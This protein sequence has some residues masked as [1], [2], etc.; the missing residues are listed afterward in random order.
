[1]PDHMHLIVEVAD[2]DAARRKLRALLGGVTRGAGGFRIWQPV[3]KAAAIPDAHHLLRQLRYVALNP[4]RA[5]L[6]ADPLSWPWSTY[7]GTLGAEVDAWVQLERIAQALGWQR[8]GAESVARRLHAFVSIDPT[9]NVSGSPLPQEVPPSLIAKFPLTRV[10]AAA[11]AATPLAGVHGFRRALFIRLARQQGW[12]DNK[13]L[14]AAS[15][16]SVNAVQRAARQPSTLVTC[17]AMCLGDERLLVGYA[18]L[19]DQNPRDLWTNTRLLGPHDVVA[20]SYSR[21]SGCP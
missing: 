6:V 16:M 12:T 2:A 7:R 20:A 5:G 15:Q 10:L 4:C 19:A 13:L 1:M 17:G 11:V 8:T 9:V 21:R 18:H 3:P 14:A